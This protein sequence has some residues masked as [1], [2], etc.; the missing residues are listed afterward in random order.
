M[1]LPAVGIQDR[2]AV[3]KFQRGRK[4]RGTLESKIISEGNLSGG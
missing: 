3:L 2:P 4:S 1:L